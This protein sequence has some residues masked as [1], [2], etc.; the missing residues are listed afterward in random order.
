[1]RVV[2]LSYFRP[3]YS[4]SFPMTMPVMMPMVFPVMMPM[5]VRNADI[6]NT[7]DTVT[8]GAQNMTAKSLNMMMSQHG[9][10]NNFVNTDLSHNNL[11]GQSGS[12]AT[13]FR[14]SRKIDFEQR[15][16]PRCWWSLIIN[17]HLINLTRKFWGL[18]NTVGFNTKRCCS[19]AY[20]Y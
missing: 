6:Q 8:V 3:A 17:L 7:G 13:N 19:T 18:F 14:R 10:T 9:M 4:P 2:V 15:S 11:R 20:D 5:P 16:G 1:M 12:R